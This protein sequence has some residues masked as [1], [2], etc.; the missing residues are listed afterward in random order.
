MTNSQSSNETLRP[1]LFKIYVG[2]SRPK[3]P[4]KIGAGLIRFSEMPKSILE[5]Q[6]WFTVYGS[7]HVFLAYP[8]HSKRPFFKVNEAVG[9]GVRWVAEGFFVDHV[10]IQKLYCFEL[11]EYI[12]RT[13]KNYGDLMSGAP[14]PM[15]ENI[16]I[17]IQRVVK[18]LFRKDIANPFDNNERAIKCSELFFR[19]LFNHEPGLD[20][21]KVKEDLWNLKGEYLSGDIDS[22]GVRDTELVLDWLS[23]KGYCKIARAIEP[24]QNSSGLMAA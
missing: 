19:A 14:Y 15:L 21:L 16:G 20:I 11:P 18:W 5:P 24:V 23:E 1:R 4:L 6:T 13:V 17:A 10:S 22:L 9:S 12:Y 7:S 3:N 8:A 2:L